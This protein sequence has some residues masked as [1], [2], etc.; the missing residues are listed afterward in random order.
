MRL[1][2]LLP[3]YNEAENLEALVK[4]LLALSITGLEII[5]IDDNSPDGTGQLADRLASQ[6]ATVS[7]IHRLAKAGL[8]PAY[9]AGFAEV[10]QRQA[11]LVIEMDSDF[12]H[13][14]SDLP[15]LLAAA[16]QADV[17]IGSRY[18]QG[19][20]VENWNALRRLISRFGNWY[21]RLILNLPIR[22]LT[23]GFVV[24][25]RPVLDS[26]DLSSISS[27]GYNFQIEMKAKAS[28]Q[29][30]RLV[31]VPIIFRERRGNRS[32]FSIGIMLESFIKV[33]KLR[34]SRDFKDKK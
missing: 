11:D 26:L 15:R 23:A 5:I 29:G 19:G 16:N 30:W 1:S 17:V 7:V 33:L 12:S 3:T 25:R 28:W 22:D 31:E 24:Y 21:A 2:L 4:A 13:Q 8:G 20:G 10:S 32:K 14:P 9:L 6:L 27:L 18:V 34:N